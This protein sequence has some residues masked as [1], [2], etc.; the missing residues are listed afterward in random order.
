LKLEAGPTPFRDALTIRYS[1]PGPLSVDVFDVRGSRVHR[2]VDRA[3]GAGSVSWR[4][5]RSGA[6]VY[7]VRLTG[8]QLSMVRR[9]VRLD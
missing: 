1:G 5:P 6:G 3:S 7:F 8:P 9:V 4:P 2:V